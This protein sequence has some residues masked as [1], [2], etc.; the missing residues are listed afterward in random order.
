MIM[1]RPVGALIALCATL[2][3]PPRIN[4]QAFTPPAGVGQV[5]AAGQ[6]V[7]NTGHWFSD[8]FFLP[9]GQSVTMS[10]HLEVD[11][12]ITDRLSVSAGVP[13]VFAKYKGALPPPSRLAIDACKCWHS[14]FQDLSFS[15][16]Y[17]FGN[18]AWAITPVARYVMPTHDYRYKGEAV[19]GRNLQEA[20]A[21]V[22]AGLR[23]PGI[24]RRA[25]VGTGYTYSFVQKPLREISINRSNGYF[26]VG[27]ALTDRFFVR[28]VST[29]QKTHGGLRVGSPT[30]KPF[31]P[32]G[33]LN[34]PQRFAQRD[35]LLSTQYWHAGGGV[36]YAT[37]GPFDVFA[38]IT[39]YVWG[40]NA[41]RGRTFTAGATWY[42]DRSN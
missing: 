23:L 33:E 19:V 41:H 39:Q 6:F 24:L 13:Y 17:R 5:T 4:A 38:E 36:S 28:G 31:F 8:G 30:G 10:L 21:G 35:R 9:A 7:D 12:G 15:A 34:T 11:Y 14:T 3:F 32:P 42:F 26:E 16:R 25:S 22:N 37:A 2:A 1:K 27:Y 18:D 29:W 40:R 20:Q